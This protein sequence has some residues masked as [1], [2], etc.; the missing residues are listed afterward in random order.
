[1]A[2]AVFAA[3]QKETRPTLWTHDLFVPGEFPLETLE[4][5]IHAFAF[6]VLVASPDDELVKRGA[7]FSAM[8][9]NILLEIG[10]FTGA[11][12]RRRTFIVC[13]NHPRIELPSDLLGVVY[14]T[15][16]AERLQVGPTEFAS[17]V[18]VGCSQIKQ[19]I[20]SELEK[21]EQEEATRQARLKASEKGRAIQ[22]LHEVSVH[23]RDV[24]MAVQRDTFDS[25]TDQ[26]AFDLIKEKASEKILKIGSSFGEDASILQ[27]EDQLENLVQAANAALLDL[28]FP[29]ELSVSEAE[30]RDRTIEAGIGAVMGLFEG[31]NPI[32]DLSR[33]ASAEAESR[34][35]GLKHRYTDWWEKHHG[36]LEGST[37][38][39]QDSLLS[40]ALSLASD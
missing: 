15:Y 39:M 36:A 32:R 10:L 18:Q 37:L 14:A 25:L 17:A 1:M 40:A 31:R 3:L 23:L 5:E 16:D 35:T 22:R 34:V 7:T 27:V 4:R 8:R 28:P 19:A 30:A 2:E 6:A 12:G 11:L 29:Q 24:L 26:S 13:P 38:K 33:S 20:R 9:D 21:I